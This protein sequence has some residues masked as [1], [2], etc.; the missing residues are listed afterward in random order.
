MSL[1]RIV[2]PLW[3]GFIFDIQLYLPYLSGAIIMMVG[4]ALSITRLEKGEKNA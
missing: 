1:G 2:G 4:F 3:A